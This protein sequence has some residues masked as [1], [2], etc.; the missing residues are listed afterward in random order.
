MKTCI[1][2]PHGLVE[3]RI[4]VH[5]NRQA[6]RTLLIINGGHTN[7]NSLLPDEPYLL[8]AGYRLIVP[9]RPGYQ[10]TPS[11]TGR[12]AH[13]AADALAALMDA[14]QVEQID[15]IALSAGGPT[16][17][18]LASRYPKLVRRLVLQCAVTCEWPDAR[19]KRIASL[20]FRPGIERIF[21]ALFRGM[22]NTAPRFTLSK[23]MES[24]TTLNAKTIIE[25][26]DDK[27]LHTMKQFVATQR[28]GSGFINDIQHDSGDLSRIK[29]ETLV[30]FSKYDGTIPYRHVEYAME[31]I[32]HAKLCLTEAESHL[33]WF[34]PHYAQARDRLLHF[35]LE[36]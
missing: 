5:P 24:L 15:V 31:R 16:G 14:L 23:L 6:E 11:A 28:S 9:S 1:E 33:M 3:Y 26:L 21:W 2:T 27:Q 8:E 10:G 19:Q 13:E 20:L 29:A 18:Q 32:P 25:T 4:A 30:I 34:S 35:L 36:D 22:L 7:C 12:T 17:L